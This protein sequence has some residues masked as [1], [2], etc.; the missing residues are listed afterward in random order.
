MITPIWTVTKLS[1]KPDVDGKVDYVV[2]AYW[3]CAATDGGYS[4]IVCGA[5]M[6]KVDTTKPD[7]IPYS[8]LTEVEVL[9]W[10]QASIGAEAVANTETTVLLQIE[11]QKNPPI[12]QPPLPW[13]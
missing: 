11:A 3:N 6:F 4:G 9:Q 7:Y 5:T 8:D 1:C 13:A 10:V 2:T 12:V